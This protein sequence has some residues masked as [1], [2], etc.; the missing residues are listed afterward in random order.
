MQWL[1][2]LAAH[3]AIKLGNTACYA[4]GR[5][6]PVRPSSFPILLHHGQ[7]PI[8]TSIV[9]NLQECSFV[10]SINS[11]LT[12]KGREKEMAK[13]QG[14]NSYLAHSTAGQVILFIEKVC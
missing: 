6:Y 8:S 9:N 2:Y 13:N 1:Q 14:N 3:W 10:E 5:T 12:V 11:Y 4:V 7:R